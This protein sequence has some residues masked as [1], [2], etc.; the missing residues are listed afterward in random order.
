MDC[1]RVQDQ[2]PSASRQDTATSTG[3]TEGKNGEARAVKSAL[4]EVTAHPTDTGRGTGG[5]QTASSEGT[6]ATTLEAEPP[7]DFLLKELHYFTEG[8]IFKIWHPNNSYLHNMTFV[9]VRSFNVEGSIAPIQEF[10]N[11]EEA[12]EFMKEDN[13][14]LHYAEVREYCSQ[15]SRKWEAEPLIVQCAKNRGLK[16]YAFVKL[17]L[18][19][20]L[21]FKDPLLFVKNRGRMGTEQLTELQQ[22]I[23]RH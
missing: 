17:K 8:T 1:E 5:A 21:N 4:Q 7:Q 16:E 11:E 15:T 10:E 19:P 23:R 13:V 9:I 2:L 12:Q 6:S 22:K 20:V 3:V 14:E 18:T